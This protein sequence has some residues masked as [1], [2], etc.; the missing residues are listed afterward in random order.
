MKTALGILLTAISCLCTW[1]GCNYHYKLILSDIENARILII[2]KEKMQLILIDYKGDTL[3]HAPVA[4]GKA[5]GDKQE[6]GD[7]CTPEGIFKVADIQNSSKWTHDF[8][9]GKGNISGAYGNHFIRLNVPGH[10]GIGIHGTHAPESIGKRETEGCIRLNND[11][12]ERLVGL[13]Y[14]PLTVIITPSAMDEKVNRKKQ[15]E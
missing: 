13:I 6:Q 11:D 12:L 2:S 1:I 10:K 9:D 15:K 8:G 5:Y 3:F 4:T 7:M 14:P